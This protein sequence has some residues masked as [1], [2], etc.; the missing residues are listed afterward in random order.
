MIPF[1]KSTFLILLVVVVTVALAAIVIIVSR[2]VHDRM[3]K[4]SPAGKTIDDCARDWKAFSTSQERLQP[5]EARKMDE[6]SRR[7]SDP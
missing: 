1:T 7:T 6:I 4:E 5:L 3:T 2:M